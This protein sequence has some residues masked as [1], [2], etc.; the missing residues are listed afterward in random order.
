MGERNSEIAL[1]IEALAQLSSSKEGVTRLPFTLE[2][3]QAIEYLKKRLNSMGKQVYVDAY[4]N[5]MSSEPGGD[6]VEGKVYFLSHYDSVPNGGRYDG[7]AGIVMGLRLIEALEK[8]L[9]NRVEVIAF[10]LEESAAYGRASI[11]SKTFFEGENSVPDYPSQLSDGTSLRASLRKK[12]YEKLS[13]ISKPVIDEKAR[14]IEVH[15]DQ[16]RVLTNSGVDIGVVGTIAGQK[17]LTLLF[18]GSTGH[19]SLMDLNSR[20]DSLQC[21]SHVIV[22]VGEMSQ[23]YNA[24]GIVGTVTRITNEPNVTNM[25]PGSTELFVDIRG[26]EK[27]GVER[28]RSELISFSSRQAKKRNL[29]FSWNSVS[30]YDPAV[31]HRDFTSLL[32]EEMTKAGIASL[33]MNSMAWHDSA[34]A[35]KFYKTS[36][37]FVANPAGVSHSPFEQMDMDAFR[38]LLVFFLSFLG[39]THDPDKKR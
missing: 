10:N 37:L 35:V 18:N 16:S 33:R 32:E 34:E 22:K 36:L 39:G 31:M 3:D 21:A 29:S 12:Q 15:V 7:V 8:P 2:N 1:D 26:T 13:E 30:E 27:V 25:I 20:K 4:G 11:G 9:R 5:I 14:F 38:R 24:S 23:T 28:Y 19:S 17:R 6:P